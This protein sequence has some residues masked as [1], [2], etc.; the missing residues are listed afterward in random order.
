MRSAATQCRRQRASRRRGFSHPSF[1]DM[2]ALAFIAVLVL[3]CMFV[4]RRKWDRE[5]YAGQQLTIELSVR[6]NGPNGDGEESIADGQIWMYVLPP[7]A[8]DWSEAFRVEPI[9]YESPL[10][11]TD[12]RYSLKGNSDERQPEEEQSLRPPSQFFMSSVHHLTKARL[13]CDFS[14]NLIAGEWTIIAQFFPDP[15]DNNQSHAASP[16][17]K[18]NLRV[19][20]NALDQDSVNKQSLLRQKPLPT[21]NSSRN[22]PSAALLPSTVVELV[23]QIKDENEQAAK[24]EQAADIFSVLHTKDDLIYATFSM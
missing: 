23:S 13:R 9:D 6:S 10:M 5:I 24:N 4:G 7:G 18:W 17:D 8:I 22:L 12:I 19:S 3:F 2:L 14:E 1:V 20:C 16:S 15:R 11:G 21:R